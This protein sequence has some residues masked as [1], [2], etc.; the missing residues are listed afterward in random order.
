MSQKTLLEEIEE[1]LSRGDVKTTET[2]FG[3]A[4]VNDGKFVGDLR[5]GRRVWPETAD[6]VRA[7]ILA[8]P[9]PAGRS[10]GQRREEAA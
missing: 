3:I 5:R 8:N 9:A 10:D 7:Y 2:A 4:T 6:K 1:F